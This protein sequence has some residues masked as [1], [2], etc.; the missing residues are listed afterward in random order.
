MLLRSLAV[1]LSMLLLLLQSTV[2]FTPEDFRV[3]G[4]EQVEPAFGTFEGEM[5]AGLLPIDQESGGKLMCT[6][7]MQNVHALSSCCSR[8][9]FFF[10]SLAF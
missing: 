6:C 1:A 10:S 2:A 7:W 3:K 9:P 5:Y 4:L 8:C